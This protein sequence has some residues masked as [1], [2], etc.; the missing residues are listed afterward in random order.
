MSIRVSG[1]GWLPDH[2]DFRDFKYAVSA[3]RQL[4]ASVD[5]RTT[6]FLPPV[7]D[8]ETLGSCTANA[9]ASLFF[10]VDKKQTGLS[11]LP[12]RLYVYYNT[13]KAENTVHM[14]SGAQ[15]R[16]AIKS[17]IK[18]GACIEALWPYHT[19]L[20]DSTPP[21]I[22]YTNAKKHAATEYRSVRQNDDVKS[23][24]AEG[25]PVTCGITVFDSF[26]SEQVANTGIVP[27][28]QTTESSVGGHAILLVGY[29]DTGFIA[30]NSWG[31]DWGMK[32]FFKIPYDYIYSPD[33]AADFWTVKAVSTPTL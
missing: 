3:P 30:M 26:E 31:E 7:F 15:I 32:G 17:I 9:L 27:L 19:S 2:P 24:L 4:P 8:Q 25:Y 28:P 11:F 22:C 16:T 23:V 12:S 13:R 14:D 20:F 5:L 18:E 6:G 21:A 33:L 29:D 1:Y 10:F